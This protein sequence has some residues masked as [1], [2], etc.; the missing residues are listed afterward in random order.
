VYVARLYGYGMQRGQI[1]S[2]L[3]DHLT[4]PNGKPRE[5]RLAKA[6]AK[7][8]RWERRQQ[9]RDLIYHTAVHEVDA[10]LPLVLKGVVAKA[11]RGRVDAARLALEVTGRHNPKGEQ[12]AP[13]VV[14]AIDG[15]PRPRQIADSEV[16]DQDAVER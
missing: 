3:L 14:I 2:G 4:P 13:T 16:V 5:Y 8:R 6:R 10:Q 15:V 11:K 1:A 7:L 12:A 9:F